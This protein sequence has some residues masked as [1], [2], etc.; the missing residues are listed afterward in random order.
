MM[1]N[2]YT[3]AS[4]YEPST[5]GSDPAII[6]WQ[7]VRG[8]TAQVRIEFVEADETTPIDTSSWTYIASAYDP[9]LD[10]IDELD[11]TPGNGFVVVTASADTTKLWGA[12]YGSV[13]AEL[14]FD[15]QVTKQ[16]GTI[17]TPV[18]GNIAVLGDVTYGGS[19]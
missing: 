15:L 10:T 11:V 17:W 9:R 7:V 12:G 18:L 16:D 5:F 4:L 2:C 1:Y 14:L 19:L 6:K 13:I 3:M 8:D